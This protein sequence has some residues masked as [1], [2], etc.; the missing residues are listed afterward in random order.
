VAKIMGPPGPI[1][2]TL[3]ANVFKADPQ[4]P[5]VG[6]PQLSILQR[7]LLTTDGTVT[8]IVETYAGE[9]VR[10]VKLFQDVAPAPRAIEWLE[11]GGGELVLERRILLQGTVSRE[12]FLYAESFIAPDRLDDAVRKPIGHLII[13]HRLETFREILEWGTE[14]AGPLNEYFSVPATAPTIFRTY[15]IFTN[16]RP[17]MMITEKFPHNH[18]RR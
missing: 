12:N 7:I 10:V 13:E 9:S 6:Y 14:A 1:S 5:M 16:G 11:L 2:T 4:H 17:I 3:L 8:D 15:R 18:Y